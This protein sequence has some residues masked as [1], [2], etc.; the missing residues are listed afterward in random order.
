MGVRYV[1]S[2]VVSVSG[3]VIVRVSEVEPSPHSSNPDSLSNPAAGATTATSWPS[4]NSPVDTGSSSMVNAAG[5]V[6]SMVTRRCRGVTENSSVSCAPRL[7]VTL[8]VMMSSV[9]PEWPSIGEVEGRPRALG[10][11][12]LVAVGDV[13]AVLEARGPLHLQAARLLLVAPGR[14]RADHLIDGVRDRGIR[15]VDVED[16][17]VVAG[18]DVL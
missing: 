5:Q 3:T 8:A 2:S 7:S 18:V 11:V 15:P 16:R 1:A 6:L 10:A 9:S 14:A 13:V 4:V 12:V 17:S